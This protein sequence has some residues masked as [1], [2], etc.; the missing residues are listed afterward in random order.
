MRALYDRLE[1]VTRRPGDRETQRL[2]LGDDFDGWTVKTI[3]PDRL[4][5]ERQGETDQLILR[6]Y[7]NAPA[8]APPPPSP[9]ARRQAARRQEAD[10]QQR[11]PQPPSEASG[12]D[13]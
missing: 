7:T 11:A 4:V 3:E 13:P 6:D 10:R 5:L 9:I 2:R 12:N 8:V 1:K